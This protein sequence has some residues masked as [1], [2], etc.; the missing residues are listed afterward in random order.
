ML[1]EYNVDL[2]IEINLGKEL[3]NAMKLVND[4]RTEYQQVPRFYREDDFVDDNP[5]QFDL[6]KPHLDKLETYHKKKAYLLRI[7]TDYLQKRYDFKLVANQKIEA[8]P[9]V[10]L[11][12]KNGI[13]V[14]ITKR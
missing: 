8:M 12:P 14:D 4:K 10:T 1:L 3:N 2:L 5:Y 13:Q 7:K 6:I 9:Y 11:Q